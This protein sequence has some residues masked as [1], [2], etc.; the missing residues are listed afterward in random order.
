MSVAEVQYAAEVDSKICD[1]L[2]I[3]FGP[4][5]SES[6]AICGPLFMTYSQCSVSSW[7]RLEKDTHRYIILGCLYVASQS[8]LYPVYFP[9]SLASA[10]RARLSRSILCLI[11][12][13]SPAKLDVSPPGRPPPSFCGPVKGLAGVGAAAT[14]SG[15]ATSAGRLASLSLA[16]SLIP[17]RLSAFFFSCSSSFSSL[18]PEGTCAAPIQS[19]HSGWS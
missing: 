5:D 8:D 12:G 10:A 11:S 9:V 7:P 15:A 6:N 16:F 13:V 1:L 4:V 18:K 14:G 19:C 3:R 2:G 17:L